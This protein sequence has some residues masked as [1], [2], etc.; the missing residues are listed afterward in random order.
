MS[1]ASVTLRL[2]IVA[3]IVGLGFG[4]YANSLHAPFVFDD[5]QNIAQNPLIRVPGWDGAALWRAAFESP[6]PRPVANLSFALSWVLGD[7]DP[8]AFHCFNVAIHIL[9]AL[10]VYALAMRVLPEAARVSGRELSGER[11]AAISATAGLLF[12][13]HPVATQ[14]VTYI[15]QRMTSLAV[16]FGLIAFLLFLRGRDAPAG[17]R[18]VA[19]WFGAALA[20][21]LS[22]GSKQI[23]APLP[24]FALAYEWFF[25]QDLSREWLWRRRGWLLGVA[26][27]VLAGVLGVAFFHDFALQYEHRPFSLVERQLTQFRVIWFYLGLILVPSPARLNLTHD[28]A[29]S[30]S[31]VDPVTT[32]IALAGLVGLVG[33]AV[34]VARRERL[35]SFAIFWFLG[36]LAIE[37]SIVALELVYEH[38]LYLPLV[39]L[40]ILAA[41]GIF[42][43]SPARLL[44]AIAVAGLVVGGMSLWT[45]ER[46]EHWRDALTL[47]T[48]AVAKSPGDHRAHN[49]LGDA[50]MREGD[51][52]AARA[53]FE[54]SVAIAPEYARARHNLAI[55]LHESGEIEAALVRYR[56]ALDLE[57]ANAGIHR[58]LA[59]ALEAAGEIDAAL[60]AY[61]RAIALSPHFARAHHDLG[62]LR[63]KTGDVDTGL[64]RL[65]RACELEPRNAQSHYVLGILLAERSRFVPAV[66]ALERA[67]RIEPDNAAYRTVL[68]MAL[69]GSGERD[70]AIAQLREALR[71]DPGSAQ[72]RGVLQRL[73]GTLPS[74]E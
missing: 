16:C 57:P 63:V 50:H 73:E 28:F 10:L 34:I 9:N 74:A 19:C 72:A 68:G 33:F 27:V 52:E 1:R 24:L 7:G 40:A 26:S 67:S 56:E 39:W 44:P 58:N 35:L 2:L 41:D 65:E 69:A 18:R 31:L 25:H 61:E 66:A 30:H 71:I 47:W 64:A 59:A 21:G 53:A 23:A 51:L 54:H 36:T 20:W 3:A 8:F 60:A 48:D 43:L 12:V 70:A 22:V 29:I 4:L 37:S 6:S 13:A 15:V 46:N 45:I 62:V 17:R 14:A 55:A 42:R 32:L 5:L 38:R 11:R 49:N